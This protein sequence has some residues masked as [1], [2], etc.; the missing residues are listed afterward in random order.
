[1]VRKNNSALK[2]WNV[3]IAEDDL[4]S[5]AHLLK[6]LHKIADCQTVENG[7]EAIKA[8][9]RAKKKKH[10]FDFILLD[11][12]MPLLSGFEV[13]KI[14]RTGEEAVSNPPS[15]CTRIIIITA[16]KD[17]LM[18]NYNMGWDEYITK[19]IDA[20]ILIKK[21]NRVIESTGK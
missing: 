17:S 8:Y 16:Y 13:L 19:P 10:P 11:V 21:M 9:R 12:T 1:M 20:G 5:R 2:K 6:A 3:L 4:Q 14:I 7:E 18:E 15:K